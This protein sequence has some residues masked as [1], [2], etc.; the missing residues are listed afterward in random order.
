MTD[1]GRY[2]ASAE[3]VGNVT[4]KY[5]FYIEPLNKRIVTINSSILFDAIGLSGKILD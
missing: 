2:L 3:I 5:E 4:G 1:I